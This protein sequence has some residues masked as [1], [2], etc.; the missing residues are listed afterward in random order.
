MCGKLSHPAQARL[1]G[2][3][4]QNRPRCVGIHMTS[5]KFV[6]PAATLLVTFV[7]AS[8]ASRVDAQTALTGG[9]NG[10]I[11]DPTGAR[12]PGAVV[13]IASASLAVQRETTTGADGKFAVGGLVPADDYA[14]SITDVGIPRMAP[15]EPGGGVERDGVH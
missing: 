15:Y 14:L 8:A 10:R 11:S 12:V 7:L 1:R 5:E 2:A 6:W 3:E 13:E 4:I 9:V